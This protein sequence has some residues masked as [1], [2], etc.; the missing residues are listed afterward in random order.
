M[1]VT[2]LSA[3]GLATVI[4]KTL[5]EC[6]LILSC[7]IAQCYDGTS[8]MPGMYNGVQAQVCKLTG[9]TC[10]YVHCYAHRVN[11]VLVNI[12]AKITE[13]SDFFGLLEAVYSFLCVY[14][15]S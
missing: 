10:V 7:R 8:V 6:G 14:N 12:C 2:D 5:N 3:T 4:I 11:L 15:T 9:S 13:V 1:H